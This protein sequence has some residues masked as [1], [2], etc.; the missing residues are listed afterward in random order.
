VVDVEA[1]TVEM[2]EESADYT[3]SPMPPHLTLAPLVLTATAAKTQRSNIPRLCTIHTRDHASGTYLKLSFPP[4]RLHDVS[5][6]KEST[7][8]DIHLQIE[9]LA[10]HISKVTARI[11]YG[12]SLYIWT[13]YIMQIYTRKLVATSYTGI[14]WHTDCLPP[15]EGRKDL[16]KCS[17]IG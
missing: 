15:A 10:V 9:V 12:Y 7:A 6:V 3:T 5:C 17:Q 2:L 13:T 4:Y 16:R 14:G 1:D 8:L 11:Q